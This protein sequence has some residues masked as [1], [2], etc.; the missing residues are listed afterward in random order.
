MSEERNVPLTV[1]KVVFRSPICLFQKKSRGGFVLG[2][3]RK[4]A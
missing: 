2:G 1:M 4:F 3:K